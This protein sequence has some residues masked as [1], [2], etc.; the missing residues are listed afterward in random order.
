[1][2]LGQK[3]MQKKE[4]SLEER[5][6]AAQRAGALA[7]IPGFHMP[8]SRQEELSD[9]LKEKIASCPAGAQLRGELD[10][11]IEGLWSHAEKVREGK[12]AKSN[13]VFENEM[14]AGEARSV[15]AGMRMFGSVTQK[16]D[17]VT[18]NYSPKENS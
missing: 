17:L 3:G 6:D 7:G 14:V 13:F 1:M 8:R 9:T 15:L 2:A 11:I 16:G 18:L 10:A 5:E 4:M 12:A